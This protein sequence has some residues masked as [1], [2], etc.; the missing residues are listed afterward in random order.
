[1]YVDDILSGALEDD[2]ALQLKDELCDLLS[3]GVFN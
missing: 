2:S 1:M 3:K